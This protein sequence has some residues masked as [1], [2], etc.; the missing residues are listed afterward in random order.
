MDQSNPAAASGPP[1]N[2]G[3]TR[4]VSAALQEQQTRR[5]PQLGSYHLLLALAQR[6]GPMA[7]D[8]AQGVNPPELLTWLQG[9][10]SQGDIGTAVD[11]AGLLA[12]AMLLA[13]SRGRQ[14]IAERD[15]A[16]LILRAA[17]Y[18]VNVD[19]P[20]AG[21]VAVLQSPP[22]AGGVKDAAPPGPAA[23]AGGSAGAEQADAAQA[24]PPLVIPKPPVDPKL[25]PPPV[26]PPATA[27]SPAAAGSAFVYTPRGGRPTPT[28]DKYGQDL[29]RM[30]Q[31]GRLRP[32][33]GRETEVEVMI[34]VL[35]RRIKRNPVLLGPAGVGKTALVEGL[36]Q[37]IVS[38]Q[39]PKYLQGI[40]LLSLTPSAVVGATQYVAQFLEKMNAILAEAS[41]PG[42]ILFIDE[43]HTLVGMGGNR[44][45][46]DMASLIKPVLARGDIACIAATTDN[47]WRMYFESDAALERRFQPIRVQELSPEASLVIVQNLRDSV[48]KERGIACQDSVLKWLVDFAGR[49]LYNRHF[50]DKAVDL[51]EQCLAYAVSHD[52]AEITRQS[53]EIVAQRLVGMPLELGERLRLL[54]EKLTASG[55]LAEEQRE[56]LLAR[57]GVTLRG[58]D[59]RQE[60]PN[61]VV[62]MLG[63][64]AAQAAELAE[65]I[66]QQ[67]FGNGERVVEL[68]FSRMTE[69]HNISMLI[70]SPPGYVGYSDE[71]PIHAL[72]QMPWSVVLG[73]SIE[74]AH[75]T[76][77]SVFSQALADGS[78]LD[79][80]GRNIVFSESVVVLSAGIEPQHGRSIGFKP[81][82]VQQA[83]ALGLAGLIE[84]E[85]GPA[86]AGQIDIVAGDAPE[87]EDNH[88]GWLENQ[89]LPE[90]AAR[91]TRQGLPVRF[92]ASLVEWLLA[93]E[94]AET[95][96]Q[97]WERLLDEKI[98]PL[99]V[100]RLSQGA[101]EGDSLVVK[102]ADGAL[103]VAADETPREEGHADHV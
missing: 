3:A 96:R 74:Y 67:L 82:G 84:R 36:A 101:G 55:L 86:L 19:I 52:A 100:E 98:G 7:Q 38:G 64:A 1:M 25:Q 94:K 14:D 21:T 63:E 18:A 57:L 2:P 99:L 68:D 103:T 42:I 97:N 91:Y 76:I 62:L 60:R 43:V 45:S 92:D 73:T 29:T 15:L 87:V 40:R 72:L 41:Q 12:H 44:G 95:R 8:L 58:L 39:V 48:Q 93:Q 89:L 28:L 88:R 32:M 10:L 90:L 49:F 75:P 79:G 20:E 34:E 77:R 13:A 78:M 53:A 59:V 23:G 81:G 51:Y 11:L 54:D 9:K 26:Q 37:R 56:A 22:Q 4:L 83:E 35:C 71:L 30:A 31:E 17:G 33:L 102:F 70:G 66:A 46:D 69:D 6:H 5:H 65:L 85:L 50:P 47:E 80:R 24:G 16:A 27:D 61:A